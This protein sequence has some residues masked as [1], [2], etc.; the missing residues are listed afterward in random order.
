MYLFESM[1][2]F[3]SDKYPG[4]E[5]LCRMV[6]PFFGFLRGLRTG[7]IVAAAACSPTNSAQGFPVLHSLTPACYLL[8]FLTIA[9]LT[10]VKWELIMLLICTSCT[11]SELSLTHGFVIS[12]IGLLENIG[13]LS[14]LRDCRSSKCC[15]VSL[16]NIK[17]NHIP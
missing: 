2:L 11:S 14:Y 5:L 15:H 4:V 9:N 16:Y 3:S 17:N 8:I 6:C 7:S 13:S 12:C 1:F 10:S